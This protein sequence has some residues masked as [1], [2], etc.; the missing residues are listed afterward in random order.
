MQK[1]N[2]NKQ[3]RKLAK[4]LNKFYETSYVSN[5]EDELVGYFIIDDDK[6]PILNIELRPVKDMVKAN[7]IFKFNSLK[8]I[9]S[10]HSIDFTFDKP[11]HITAKDILKRG[12]KQFI[13][14]NNLAYKTILSEKV[15]VEKLD[16]VYSFLN[17]QGFKQSLVDKTIFYLPSELSCVI[18]KVR[19]DDKLVIEYKNQSISDFNLFKETIKK[20]KGIK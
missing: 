7:M 4:E 15:S 19:V 14:E 13:K 5:F 16:K 10:K 1:E 17:S 6:N 3:M 18:E 11:V 9:R 8:V 2:F 20:M 12:Y